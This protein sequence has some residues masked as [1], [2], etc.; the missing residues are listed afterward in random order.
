MLQLPEDQIGESYDANVFCFKKQPFACLNWLLIIVM[1]G[2][3]VAGKSHTMSIF[4]T[5]STKITPCWFSAL[6]PQAVQQ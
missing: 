3:N 1:E 2:F 5:L 4:C 6:F